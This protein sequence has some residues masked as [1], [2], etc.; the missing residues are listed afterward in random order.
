[1]FS[2]KHTALVLVSTCLYTIADSYE[3]AIAG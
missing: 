1:M 3:T 2:A